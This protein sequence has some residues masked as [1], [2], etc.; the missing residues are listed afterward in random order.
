LVNLLV[1]KIVCQSITGNDVDTEEEDAE[2]PAKEEEIVN[3]DD[4]FKLPDEPSDDDDGI[5]TWL[6][7]GSA[8][9]AFCGN[10]W[11]LP[12]CPQRRDSFAGLCASSETTQKHPS[13]KRAQI[14]ILPQRTR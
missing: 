1:L 5:R 4:F 7:A 6:T 8:S 10:K 13:P 9:V 14:A 2:N 3:E 11:T 12:A